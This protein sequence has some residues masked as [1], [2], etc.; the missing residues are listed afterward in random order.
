MRNFPGLANWLET[1][2]E[3]EGLRFVYLSNGSRTDADVSFSATAN[4]TEAMLSGRC[5]QEESPCP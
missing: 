5:Q 2:E 1:M 3:I 4:L